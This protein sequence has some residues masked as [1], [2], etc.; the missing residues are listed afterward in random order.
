MQWCQDKKNLVI[1]TSR[2]GPGTL[3]RFLIENRQPGTIELEV[4]KRVELKGREL[5]EHYREQREIEYR[6][7]KEKL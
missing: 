2:P 6:V 4:R 3:G 1:L 5:E 7:K